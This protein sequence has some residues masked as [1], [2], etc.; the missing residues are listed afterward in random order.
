MADNT[1]Y[2]SDYVLK[3]AMTLSVQSQGVSTLWTWRGSEDY[4]A[5]AIR[6]GCFGGL[7]PDGW[8]V[9]RNTPTSQRWYFEKGSAGIWGHAGIWGQVFL[10]PICRTL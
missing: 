9:R 2:T 4:L 8:L 5:V 1:M 6:W 10:W 3:F 7:D